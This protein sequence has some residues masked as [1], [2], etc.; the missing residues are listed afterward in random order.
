MNKKIEKFANDVLKEDLNYS[1][2]ISHNV[3]LSGNFNRV[4]KDLDESVVVSN[5]DPNNILTA[6]Q[7]VMHLFNRLLY[8]FDKYFP[9]LY[10]YRSIIIGKLLSYDETV[11]YLQ[12]KHYLGDN[13]YIKFFTDSINLIFVKGFYNNLKYHYD[14]Y[15]DILKERKIDYKKLDLKKSSHLK[16]LLDLVSDLAFCDKEF[17]S[18]YLFNYIDNDIQLF[19]NNKHRAQANIDYKEQCIWIS[20]VHNEKIIEKY[21]MKKDYIKYFK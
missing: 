18:Y 9:T 4:L 5:V 17:D 16:K 11:E 20:K 15:A 7:Q 21:N 19:V 6:E 1:A 12:S 2:F 14:I 10:R 3:R 13:N 8:W